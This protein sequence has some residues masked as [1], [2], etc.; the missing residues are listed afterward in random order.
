MYAATFSMQR[1][2]FKKVAFLCFM[3]EHLEATPNALQW[4]AL[5]EEF[6]HQS[7]LTRA[8]VLAF[9]LRP[10]FQMEHHESEQ[11][12]P[13]EPRLKLP[14]HDRPGIVDKEVSEKPPTLSQS[15]AQPRRK[16]VISPPP[17]KRQRTTSGK[18]NSTI[19]KAGLSTD[20]SAVTHRYGGC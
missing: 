5:R 15:H 13:S 4:P 12:A 14:H 11:Q 1:H 10:T 9:Y 3:E 20:P 2:Y 17:L 16:S 8:Q 18:P 7:E 19:R 6:T